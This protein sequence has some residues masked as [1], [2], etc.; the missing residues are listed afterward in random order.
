MKEAMVMKQEFKPVRNVVYGM[1]GI[2]LVFVLQQLLT[3]VVDAASH[4]DTVSVYMQG[5]IG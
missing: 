4:W 1:V 3:S 5:I 2:C